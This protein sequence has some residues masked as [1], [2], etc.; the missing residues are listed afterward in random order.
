MDDAWPAGEPVPGAVAPELAGEHPGLALLQLTLDAP[1]TA[2]SDAA[3]RGRLAELSRRWAGARAVALRAQPVPQALRV[4]FRQIGLDPDTTRT[5]VEQAVLE[6]L[7]E[8]GFRSAGPVP[9]ALTLA[10]VET[11]VPVWALDDAGLDGALGLRGARDGERLGDGP[12][13]G[14]LPAGRLV[15]AD[16]A[17]PVAVLFGPTAPEHRAGPQT[18]RLRVFAVRVPG[19]PV[20]HAEEALWLCAE[21]LHA[22]AHRR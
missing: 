1:A 21:V 11:G 9:D 5:P 20:V 18:R 12:Q 16:D 10:T 2:R 13:A 4:F 15:V 7:L 19:V 3:L 8:G 17:A 22:A 14:D 6:R